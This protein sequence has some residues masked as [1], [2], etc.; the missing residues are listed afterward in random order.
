MNNRTLTVA[1]LVVIVFI[2]FLSLRSCTIANPQLKNCEVV[3]TKIVEITEGTTQDIILHVNNTQSYYI[4][5]GLENDLN[6]DS[7]NVKVLNKTVT[8]HCPNRWTIVNPDG[9]VPH[10]SKLEKGTTVV[11]SE[12]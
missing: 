5:R 10:I 8:L 3:M 11:Y 12:F 2:I 1:L 9:I 6:L 4:Y 7:L